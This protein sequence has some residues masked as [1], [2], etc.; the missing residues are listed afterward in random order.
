MPFMVQL[1]MM[2]QHIW[3]KMNSQLI[4]NFKQSTIIHSTIIQQQMYFL[5]VFISVQRFIRT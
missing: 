2:V 4:N 5:I 3:K 1:H